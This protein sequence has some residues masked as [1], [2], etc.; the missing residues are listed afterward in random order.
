M[1]RSGDYC[2]ARENYA[3]AYT[4]DPDSAILLVNMGTLEI[5]KNEWENALHFF[6]KAVNIDPFFDKSWMGLALVH[7]EY[8]DHDLAWANIEKCLDQ[9]PSNDTALRVALDWSFKDGRTSKIVNRLQDYLSKNGED[10]EVSFLLAQIY[11]ELGQLKY[12][13]LELSRVLVL[14]PM[15]VEAVELNYIIQ[16]TKKN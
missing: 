12:A 6:R 3:K 2:T 15:R 10:I 7:R 8:G 16:G 13:E 5:Q 1:V 4:I 11:F 9:N 14:D